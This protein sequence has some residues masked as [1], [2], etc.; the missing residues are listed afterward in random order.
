MAKE[1]LEGDVKFGRGGHQQGTQLNR[2]IISGRWA[3][4]LKGPSLHN[5]WTCPRDQEFTPRSRTEHLTRCQNR[6]WAAEI[7][8]VRG[9][10]AKDTPGDQRSNTILYPLRD[11][12]PM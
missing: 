5:S 6:H 3:H 11:R 12:Q 8:K 1:G 4:N 7:T 9:G 2:E 10:T